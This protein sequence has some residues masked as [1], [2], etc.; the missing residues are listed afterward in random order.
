MYFIRMSC[1]THCQ[2]AHHHT[3]RRAQTHTTTIWSPVKPC[4]IQMLSSMRHG[5]C[6]FA[7]YAIVAANNPTITQ[8]DEHKL[9]Q[10]TFEALSRHSLK[11]LSR[12]SRHI[13]SPFKT[14]HIWSPF[15]TIFWNPLWDSRHIWSPFK[16]MRIWSPF[17]TFLKVSS[18]S[19]GST[20][21]V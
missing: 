1:H 13:R 20:Q 19:P 15:K 10:R 6:S 3:M 16:T 18:L 12:H 21:W 2:Q 11:A 9:K 7:W 4:L 14:L 5:E 17:K 8:C